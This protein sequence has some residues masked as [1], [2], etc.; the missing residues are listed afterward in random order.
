MAL[1]NLSHVTVYTSPLAVFYSLEP[2]TEN[3]VHRLLQQRDLS[4]P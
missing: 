3:A 4:D 2:I 1:Q